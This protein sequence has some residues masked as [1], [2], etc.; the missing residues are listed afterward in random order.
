MAAAPVRPR[1]TPRMRFEAE[2]FRR[3]G[4]G[5]IVFILAAAVGGLVWVEMDWGGCGWDGMD[6][7]VLFFESLGR[8]CWLAEAGTVVISRFGRLWDVVR[9]VGSGIPGNVD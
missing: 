4:G 7:M 8:C 5:E 3:G 1:T 9:I 6:G 2:I